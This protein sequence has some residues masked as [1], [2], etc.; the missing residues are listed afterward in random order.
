MDQTNFAMTG[1]ARVDTLR[2]L[3]LNAKPILDQ[4][5]DSNIVIGGSQAL[6]IHGLEIGRDSQD[7][8]IIIYEP[9]AKQYETLKAFDV[10]SD[11]TSLSNMDYEVD[12]NSPRRSFKFRLN[13]REIDILIEHTPCPKEVLYYMMEVSAMHS[14]MIK[15]QSI[16]K[17]IAAKRSYRL[18]RDEGLGQ[19][20]RTKDFLDFQNLKNLNFNY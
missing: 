12:E 13:G 3:L 4:L 18:R 6:K 8:D 19:Y 5:S 2:D 14:L 15:V 1:T 10:F 16:N 11:R 9:T 7:L 20:S 17:V